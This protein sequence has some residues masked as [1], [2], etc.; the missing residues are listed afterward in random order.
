MKRLFALA[1]VAL[2]IIMAVSAQTLAPTGNFGPNVTTS[3]ING[4][5]QNNWN[6]SISDT[7][8]NLATSLPTAFSNVLSALPDAVATAQTAEITAAK[9]KIMASISAVSSTLTTQVI[10]VQ[11]NG[12][13][14]SSATNC[15]ASIVIQ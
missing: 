4:V 15:T 13:S 11:C 10:R 9:T 7:A 8:A 3:Y 12:S 1:I 6:F 2:G 14:A 5:A